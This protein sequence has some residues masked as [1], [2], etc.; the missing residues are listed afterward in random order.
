[1]RLRACVLTGAALKGISGTDY[2][3]LLSPHYLLNFE[4]WRCFQ[5][6]AHGCPAPAPQ[7]VQRGGATRALDEFN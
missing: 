1:M 5:G 4:L 6:L 7:A 2:V 3:F